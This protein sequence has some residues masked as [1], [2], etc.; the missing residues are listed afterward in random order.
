MR[1]MP[2]LYRQ[3]PRAGSGDASQGGARINEQSHLEEFQAQP[4]TSI[5][6]ALQNAIN[7]RVLKDAMQ[8]ALQHC[9][10]NMPSSLIDDSEGLQ[11][12]FDAQTTTPLVPAINFPEGLKSD[13]SN[14]VS[15]Q[16]GGGGHMTFEQDQK[17]QT[18]FDLHGRATAASPPN[19]SMHQSKSNLDQKPAS[20]AA[21]SLR[22]S[23]SNS[24]INA[25]LSEMESVAPLAQSR[26]NFHNLEPAPIR[27]GANSGVDRSNANSIAQTSQVPTPAADAPAPIGLQSTYISIIPPTHPILEEF[28]RQY[29]PY[30]DS[31][32][33]S[34][35]KKSS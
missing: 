32:Y 35:K 31:S 25:F 8:S 29:L 21:R 10:C 30:F 14:R 17:L 33:T 6:V 34:D 11:V 18:N 26:S 4:S 12:P 28:T 24:N 5:S 2:P 19:C 13:R 9:Q 1:P 16:S 7:Q 27:N 22:G 3:T 20:L 15:T 23:D